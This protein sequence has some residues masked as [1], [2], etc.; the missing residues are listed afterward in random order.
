MRRDGVDAA[1]LQMAV[2]TNALAAPSRPKLQPTAPH[3]AAGRSKRNRRL[4]GTSD[5]WPRCPIGPVRVATPAV[6]RQAPP[7][8]TTPGGAFVWARPTRRRSWRRCDL[9]TLLRSAKSGQRPRTKICRDVPADRPKKTKRISGGWGS[10]V[11]GEAGGT[12]GWIHGLGYLCSTLRRE[13]L[14]AHELI[15]QLS[16]FLRSLDLFLELRTRTAPRRRLTTNQPRRGG[17]QC[18]DGPELSRFHSQHPRDSRRAGTRLSSL[19]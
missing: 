1:P 4:G 7:L 19:G 9:R 13:W 17:K 14:I 8:A 15:L 5:H 10:V 16:T 6:P 3:D 2:A 12:S 18:T 11:A